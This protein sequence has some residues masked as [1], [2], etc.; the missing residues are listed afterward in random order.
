MGDH[1]EKKRERVEITVSRILL[2]K[3]DPEQA[4][5]AT[6]ESYTDRTQSPPR[7]VVDVSFKFEPK[8]D[9]DNVDNLFC[10][11]AAACVK[12]IREEIIGEE[13]LSLGK[14]VRPPETNPDDEL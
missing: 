5:V 4:M 14:P 9:T 11:V 6:L 3:D 1:T 7:D 8:V 13:N 12:A 2:H 10:Q